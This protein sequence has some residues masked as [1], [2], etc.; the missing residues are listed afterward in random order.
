[1]ITFSIV[2]FLYGL[3]LSEQLAAADAVA[4]Q[5]SK[6]IVSVEGA[7]IYARSVVETKFRMPHCALFAMQIAKCL[8][9]NVFSCW[10]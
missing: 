1:M 5:P 9:R 3:Q 7:F 10:R 4:G 6:L 2:F 8:L